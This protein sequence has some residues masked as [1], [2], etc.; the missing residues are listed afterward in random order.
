MR[1]SGWE[2]W[3][4]EERLDAALRRELM[5][6]VQRKEQADLEERFGSELAF[7]TGGL[8]AKMGVGTSR[9]NVHTVRRATAGVAGWLRTIDGDSVVIG[10]DGRRDS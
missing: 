10:Y 1:A 2:T 5:E 4:A 8:R 3:L 7:G 6:L 9:M